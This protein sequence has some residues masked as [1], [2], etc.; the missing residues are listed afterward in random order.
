[1]ITEQEKHRMLARWLH[2]S[3][4]AS[5]LAELAACINLANQLQLNDVGFDMHIY[6]ISPN[7]RGGLTTEIAGLNTF[8]NLGELRALLEMSVNTL[9]EE[10]HGRNT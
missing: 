7:F 8:N 6:G 3:L 9:R 10:Q 1:M 4:A 2:G 5:K